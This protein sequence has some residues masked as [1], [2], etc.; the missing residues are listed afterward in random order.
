V[1]IDSTLIVTHPSPNVSTPLR[2]QG[3]GPNVDLSDREP[4]CVVI[5]VS[6]PTDNFTVVDLPLNQQ[7]NF[8]NTQVSWPPPEK[9]II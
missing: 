4:G 2:A 9:N 5:W 3:Q 7:T 6:D 1:S 8:Q